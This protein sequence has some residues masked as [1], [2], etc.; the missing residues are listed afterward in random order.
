MPQYL[1]PGVYVEEVPSAIKPIAGAGTSTAGFVGVVDDTVTMP[2]L[3]GR[4]GLK[5]DGTP[6]P[7]DFATPALAGVAQLVDGWE[8]FRNLFGDIQPGNSTLAHAVYGFFNNGGGRCWVTR[9]APGEDADRTDA[10]L[11]AA[12]ETFT[13][14]DEIALVAIPGAVSDAV[15][16]AI[17]DHCENPYL[18][19]RFAILDGRRTTVLTKAAIQGGTRDSSYG[20]IYYPW[21][22]VGAEDADGN[23]VYQPPSGHLA[24][25][26]ARVDTE[27]GVHKAPANEVIRGALGLE[28]LVGRQGQ[29]GLNPDGIDV[30]R[31]FDGSVTVWGARTMAG[32][33][34]P[35]WRYISSRRLFNFLRE[36]VDEGTRWAVFEP[37]APELWSKIRR[38]VGAFLT[39][40]WSSGALLGNTPEQAFYVRCDET[41]N[42]EAVRE[43][44]QLVVE[45]GVALVR[46]AEFVVFRISQWAGG[47]Q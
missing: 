46:P 17:L 47:V 12:L 28:T 19:D 13:V 25:V 5:T 10:S 21:I 15:Q 20:A 14:I 37:N 22:D 29:A 1:A 23:P 6:E 44:G 9:V 4:S 42:P 11:I 18:Q 36:S 45:I 30:I 39:T 34:Q 32:A 40:V 41:V 7:A 3:P 8:T 16:G 27:R 26:Y 38:N 43:A 31:R 2:L 24:G 33:A 35:E